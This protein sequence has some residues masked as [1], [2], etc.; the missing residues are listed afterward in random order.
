MEL[1]D[2]FSFAGQTFPIVYRDTDDFST[3]PA[4]QCRQVYGVCFCGGKIV[5]GQRRKNGQWGIIG[6]TIEPGET[7]L[8]TL[9]REIVEESNMRVTYAL[10][11]G[12]QIMYES[13]QTIYQL[14]YAAVVEPIGP[15]ISDPDGS[16]V[17]ITLVEPQAYRDYFDWGAI[18]DRIIQRSGELYQ[19]HL[20]S[21]DH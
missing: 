21:Y 2:T 3:I 9:K 4:E 7:Y 16:I 12:Y 14:R 10:P 17:A 8:Q 15:F 11:V 1:H 13:S 5:L 19:S 18:G 6:G 20:H